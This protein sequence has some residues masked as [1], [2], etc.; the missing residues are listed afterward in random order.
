LF[1]IKLSFWDDLDDSERSKLYHE[2]EDLDLEYVVDSF[3]RCLEFSEEEGK[4]LDD[5]AR[6]MG[7]IYKNDLIMISL[8][9]I[10]CLLCLIRYVDPP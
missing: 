8:I 2:L 9:L 5:Q 10:R 7:F 1:F 4:K 6:E 3:K